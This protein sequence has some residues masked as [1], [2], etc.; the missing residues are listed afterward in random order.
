MVYRYD[1]KEIDQNRLFIIHSIDLINLGKA[2]QAETDKPS[3]YLRAAFSVAPIKVHY[4]VEV[5][6]KHQTL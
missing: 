2:F 5:T 1:D 3:Q 4:F 6:K